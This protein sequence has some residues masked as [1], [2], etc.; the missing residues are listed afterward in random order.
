MSAQ[1]GEMLKVRI[2][3]VAFLTT[4]AVGFW[5]ANSDGAIPFASAMANSQTLTTDA[6]CAEEQ[7]PMPT[8]QTVQQ[9]DVLFSGGC[10]VIFIE[11]DWSP[12]SKMASNFAVYPVIRTLGATRRRQAGLLLPRRQIKMR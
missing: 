9:L 1:I 10:S 2:F 7:P 8:L 12:Y 5:L 6:P 11:A 4:N 3:Y